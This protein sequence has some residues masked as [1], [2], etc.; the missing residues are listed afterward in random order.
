MN[1]SIAQ[2]FHEEHQHLT[3]SWLTKYSQLFNTKKYLRCLLK[4]LFKNC[5][6]THITDISYSFLSIPKNHIFWMIFIKDFTV[7]ILFLVTKSYIEEQFRGL[8]K[9]LALFCKNFTFSIFSNIVKP[10]LL[11]E[12]AWHQYIGSI[13]YYT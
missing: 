3:T 6:R 9:E 5:T 1:V 13:E 10:L 8:L 2:K 4:P 7:C 11:N 12:V